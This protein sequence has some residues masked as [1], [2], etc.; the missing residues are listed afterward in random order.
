MILF[1]D[2]EEMFEYIFN[3]IHA[4]GYIIH[5]SVLEAIIE[6]NMDYITKAIEQ[7]QK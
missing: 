5:E 1:F 6:H 4:E 2:K 7:Q 3:A